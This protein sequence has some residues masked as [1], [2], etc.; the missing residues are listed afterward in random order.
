MDDMDTGQMPATST[1]KKERELTDEERI[2]IVTSLHC[3]V[4]NGELP[5]GA[6]TKIA[7]NFEVHRSTVSRIWKSAQKN[8]NGSLSN[9]ENV[10]SEKMNRGRSPMYSVEDV[11]V[12]MKNLPPEK[13]RN[14]P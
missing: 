12:V 11:H 2:A 4:K 3:T 6:L 8:V 5:H 14:T 1:G 9:F 13:K 10:R 7:K